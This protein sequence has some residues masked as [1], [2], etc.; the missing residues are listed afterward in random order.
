MA[1]RQLIR[2][3]RRACGRMARRSAPAAHSRSRAGRAVARLGR[4]FVLH[5]WGCYDVPVNVTVRNRV[6]I[7]RPHAGTPSVLPRKKK[8]VQSLIQI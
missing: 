7:T 5:R 8:K 1:G 6:A 2:N 3:K 4:S